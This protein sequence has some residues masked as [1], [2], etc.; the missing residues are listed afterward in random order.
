MSFLSMAHMYQV[1]RDMYPGEKWRNKVLHMSDNQ[2]MAI[3][4]S[5]E[6]RETARKANQPESPKTEKKIDAIRARDLKRRV[7]EKIE[8]IRGKSC[9]NCGGCCEAGKSSTD[10]YIPEQL[11][12]FD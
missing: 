10:D 7:Q 6:E 12:F 11:S 2:I 3:Y 8:E 1:V 9:V 5:K 4:F